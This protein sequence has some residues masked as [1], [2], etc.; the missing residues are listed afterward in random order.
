MKLRK[1]LVFDPSTLSYQTRFESKYAGVARSIAYWAGIVVLAMVYFYIYLFVFGFEAPKTL[2]IKKKH[3]ESYAKFMVASQ[4]VQTIDKQIHT[5]AYRD[6][7]VYRAILGLNEIS[8][9]VREAGF[10]GTERYQYLQT[11]FHN[12]VLPLMMQIDK[13]TKMAEVQ[14]RSLDIVAKDAA[15]VGDMLKH[16]P[17]IAP[18]NPIPG[19]YRYSSAF[20]T[21]RDPIRGTTSFHKGIDFAMPTG[22]HIY[23]TGDGVVEMVKVDLFGYG[24]Q[25]VIDHGFG[26]KTRYAHLSRIHVQKGQ[27][28]KRGQHIADSGNTGRSSGAH[29]HYEV[30]YKGKNINPYNFVDLEMSPKEYATMVD[31]VKRSF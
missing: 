16:V 12:D 6:D 30:I 28:V 11:Q 9:S 19:K 25:V 17:A 4:R 14:T 24:R 15:Q 22:S 13:L 27:K 29:L 26:Y 5:L 10:G 8:P 3:D 1:K 21:R 7:G 31:E 20:G 23:S 18:M 2:I